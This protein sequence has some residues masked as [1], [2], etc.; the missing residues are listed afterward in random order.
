MK[1]QTSVPVLLL[2]LAVVTGSCAADDEKRHPLEG[3]WRLL[4]SKDRDASVWIEVP[5]NQVEQKT[6]SINHTIWLVY[7][8]KAKH[9]EWGIGSSFEVKGDTFTETI[10]YVIGPD[11]L[12]KLLGTKYKTTWK[13]K[14]G[15]LH[16]VRAEDG[17]EVAFESIWERMK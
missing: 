8:S 12:K 4:K 5:A 15:K 14:D 11:G 1:L 7:D 16:T 9:G 2:F 10:Q 6:F 13:I 3:T 17:S